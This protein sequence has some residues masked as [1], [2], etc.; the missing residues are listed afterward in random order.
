MSHYYRRSPLIQ[1]GMEIPC[2]IAAKISGT[3]I[4][5]LLT[6]LTGKNLFSV[7]KF[8]GKQSW[9]LLTFCICL[10]NQL[11]VFFFIRTPFF[12]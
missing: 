3:V 12:V 6:I 5:L 11:H 4:N 10:H 8:I 1:G 2:K 9:L 7:Q